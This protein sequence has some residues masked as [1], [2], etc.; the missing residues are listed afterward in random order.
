MGSQRPIIKI[1]KLKKKHILTNFDFEKF[2][3]YFKGIDWLS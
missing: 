1:K 2:N 3:L